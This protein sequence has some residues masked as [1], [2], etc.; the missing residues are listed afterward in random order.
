MLNFIADTHTYQWR[1]KT[2]PSVTQVIGEW[3]PISVYGVE[4][5]YNVFT[6]TV[7]AAEQFVGARDFGRAVHK[8][9]SLYLRGV[10]DES[11]LHPSLIPV[12]EQFDWWVRTNDVEPVEIET[13]MYSEKYQYAGTPDL[14]CKI[15][16]QLVIVEEKTGEYGMAG[17]QLAGYDK[18]YKPH[19]FKKR[20]VLSFPKDGG[21]LKVI[22]FTSPRDWGFFQ[23]RLYQYYY[24]RRQC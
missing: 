18:L 22:P 19:L 3:Q 21:T 2:V 11:T 9:N 15:R 1:G 24:T 10:L 17:P 8:M 23:A 12:L 4:Y 14:I 6:G 20:I 5:Y 13:P 16:R 7:L